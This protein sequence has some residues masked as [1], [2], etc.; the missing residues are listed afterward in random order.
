VLPKKNQERLFK[1]LDWLT[2]LATTSMVVRIKSKE[3]YLRK[4]VSSLIVAAEVSREEDT[5]V[6]LP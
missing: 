4:T 3:K 6:N 1:R 2:A 5:K